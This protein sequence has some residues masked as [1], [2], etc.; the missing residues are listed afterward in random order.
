MKHMAPLI[1]IL[2]MEFGI[3]GG[4]EDVVDFCDVGNEKFCSMVGLV[5]PSPQ[6]QREWNCFVKGRLGWYPITATSRNQSTI[7]LGSGEAELV[8]ALS[9]DCEGMGP[10]QQWNW[11]RKPRNNAE[12]TCS[13]T[14]QILYCRIKRKGSNR[15]N[16]TY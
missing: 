7:A 9:G 4:V 3:S 8:A 6:G 11:L 14:Q 12:E 15:K 5:A 10:R 2:E 1:L 13:T 16:K